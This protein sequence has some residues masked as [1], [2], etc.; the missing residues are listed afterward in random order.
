MEQVV[1]SIPGSVEYISH[2][3]WAVSLNQRIIW[4]VKKLYCIVLYWAYDYLGPFG[5]LWVIWLDTKIVFKKNKKHWNHQLIYVPTAEES[6]KLLSCCWNI[7]LLD[8]SVSSPIW[9]HPYIKIT[10]TR[11]VA[12]SLNIR[13]WRGE[14]R[15]WGITLGTRFRLYSVRKGQIVHWWQQ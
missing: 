15:K 7:R 9:N 13:W 10:K 14:W 5:D 4:H 1:S 2:V 8:N 3:H 12:F 6:T 11:W